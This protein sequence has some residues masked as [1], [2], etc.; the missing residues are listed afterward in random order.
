MTIEEHVAKAKQQIVAWD[1]DAHW[2]N[3]VSVHVLSDSDAESL[4]NCLV[5]SRAQVEQAHLPLSIIQV[6]DIVHRSLLTCGIAR[7]PTNHWGQAQTIA[8]RLLK[9]HEVRGKTL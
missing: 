5:N 6:A 2:E 8:T 7:D 1:K 3:S 4:A 9:T